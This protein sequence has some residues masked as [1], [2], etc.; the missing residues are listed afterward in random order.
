MKI[1]FSAFLDSLVYM[2]KGLLGI[3]IV[4]GAIVVMMKLLERFTRKGGSKD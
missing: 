4:T 3:F 2:A 1:D